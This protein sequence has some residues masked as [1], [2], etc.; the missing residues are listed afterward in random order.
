MILYFQDTGQHFGN[1]VLGVPS[2]YQICAQSWRSLVWNGWQPPKLCVIVTWQQ[3]VKWNYSV[4]QVWLTLRMFRWPLNTSSVV[5]FN[6]HRCSDWI[7][8][9]MEDLFSK[10]SGWKRNKGK[11]TNQFEVDSRKTP[12]HFYI[13]C[14]QC[15]HCKPNI[16]LIQDNKLILH[17]CILTG[18]REDLSQYYWNSHAL[19]STTTYDSHQHHIY[20]S[21]KCSFIDNTHSNRH[22]GMPGQKTSSNLNFSGEFSALVSRGEL[23][24][25]KTSCQ[26]WPVKGEKTCTTPLPT[27]SIL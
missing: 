9:E 24:D 1:S 6:K 22:C 27:P 23:T 11:A 20:W 19:F 5:R 25:L 14:T 13:Y 21:M 8:T 17:I 2:W 16:H 12:A 15:V 18:P 3:D 7:Q 4:S 10:V 26:Y